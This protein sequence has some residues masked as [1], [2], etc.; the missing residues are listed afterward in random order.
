MPIQKEILSY[1]ENHTFVSKSKN[2]FLI[3][4]T[5]ILSFYIYSTIL[6]MLMFIIYMK[7]NS[8]F[9]YDFFINGLFGL[10][11]FYYLIVFFIAIFSFFLTSSLFFIFEVLIKISPHFKYIRRLIKKNKFHYLLNKY[12]DEIFIAFLFL[13]IN[14]IIDISLFIKANDA[15]QSFFIFILLV[16]SS[17]TIHI[18][19]LSFAK[20][21][22]KLISLLFTSSIIIFS[23]L[24]FIDKTAN[25]VEFG[26]Q[27][28]GVGGHDVK[29]NNID[30]NATLINGKL[31]LLSP[32]NVFIIKELDDNKSIL[33]IVERSNN[34]SINIYNNKK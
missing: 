22:T 20:V 10:S 26:L 11:I 15:I 24:F 18:S 17:A 2:I 3:I 7:E 16:C 5:G 33:S 21:K 27:Y 12:R 29:I 6:P 13:I 28:F 34:I 32:D 31:L 8:F 23:G 9:S 14:L 1:L 4:I 30:N 25:L 19:Y